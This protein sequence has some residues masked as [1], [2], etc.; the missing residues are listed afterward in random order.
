[1]SAAAIPRLSVEDY[2]AIDRAAELKSE[3]H[4]GEMF[5]MVAVS[6]AHA[7]IGFRLARQLG[8]ALED[9]PCA[10]YMAPLRVRVSARKYVYSDLL[11]ICGKAVYTDDHTDTVTNPK[12]IIEILSPSTA[13]YDYGEKFAAYRG[14]ESLGEYVLVAQDRPLIEIFRRT[15]D[16]KWLLSSFEGLDS[17][18]ELTSLGIELRLADVYAGVL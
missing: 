12:V 11:V 1:M 14:L 4:D 10:G 7:Q 9:G 18:A 17:T 5:P 16:N 13:N 15:P 2:L 8:N 6:G 3:Y